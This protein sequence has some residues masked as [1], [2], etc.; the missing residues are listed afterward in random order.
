MA[1]P[2]AGGIERTF[3]RK[4]KGTPMDSERE[5]MGTVSLLSHFLLLVL[6]FTA[7]L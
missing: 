3:E 1:F 2:Q 5:G 7:P 4:K 6:V